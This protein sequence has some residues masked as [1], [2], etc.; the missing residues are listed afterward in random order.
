MHAYHTPNP[1]SPK[2]TLRLIS[3]PEENPVQ[4][5]LKHLADSEQIMEPYT[6]PSILLF[7]SSLVH[8]P[9][10]KSAVISTPPVSLY[11]IVWSF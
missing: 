5:V 8:S 7:L 1:I 6:L 10:I 3:K 11:S 2:Q 4:T 9:P